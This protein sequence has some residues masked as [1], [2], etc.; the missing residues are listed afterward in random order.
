M[1]VFKVSL[2]SKGVLYNTCYEIQYFAE[3]RGTLLSWSFFFNNI[4][5]FMINLKVYNYFKK[6][7]S[8]TYAFLWI[9]LGF[10]NRFLTDNYGLLLPYNS[11]KKER[12]SVASYSWLQPSLN[13]WKRFTSNIFNAFRNFLK[14]LRKHNKATIHKCSKE[15]LDLQLCWKRSLLEVFSCDVLKRSF[16]RRRT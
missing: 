2:S 16:Q 5:S 13:I 1:H 15:S 4:A 3:H 7:F 11:F 9:L 8:S 10:Q 14:K 6:I 12:V